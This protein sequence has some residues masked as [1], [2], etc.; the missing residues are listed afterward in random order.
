VFLVTFNYR[1]TSFSAD[2][3]H[4]L[5]ETSI[6]I[7]RKMKKKNYQQHQY[8]RTIKATRK[9]LLPN[10]MKFARARAGVV[11]LQHAPAMLSSWRKQV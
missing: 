4:F 6:K 10:A 11:T 5:V 2:C 3:Q 9:W 8:H 1:S 7:G